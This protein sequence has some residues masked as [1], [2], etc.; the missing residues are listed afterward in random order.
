M[1]VTRTWLRVE[2]ALKGRAEPLL[3]VDVV[4]C[5]KGV[6]P[7]V[8]TTGT[9]KAVVDVLVTVISATAPIVGT[10]GPTTVSA[11][12]CVTVFT[13]SLTVT[14][15]TAAPDWHSA[16]RRVS[17]AFVAVLVKAKFSI[18]SGLSLTALNS[19]TLRAVSGSE[20]VSGTRTSVFAGAVTG[21]N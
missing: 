2:E 18:N 3:A 1:I 17:A 10:A 21:A 14:A 20:T 7:A 11:R 19:S 6:A 13:P 9:D 12:F 15:T 8:I 16:K 4:N 5:S